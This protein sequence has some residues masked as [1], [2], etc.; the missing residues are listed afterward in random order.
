MSWQNTIQWL[1]DKTVKMDIKDNDEILELLSK[2]LN[3]QGQ[4]QNI[5]VPVLTQK[6]GI[7]AYRFEEIKTNDDYI[8]YTDEDLNSL[9]LDEN[10]LL[11]SLNNTKL[12]WAG[13]DNQSNKKD[14][15]SKNW[16]SLLD[17]Q[18]DI[19]SLV[20]PSKN[21][22][23]SNLPNGVLNNNNIYIYNGRIYLN[24]KGVD[25]PSNKNHIPLNGNKLYKN[26][27]EFNIGNQDIWD[28]I[29]QNLYPDFSPD[30]SSINSSLDA[31][32]VK[33]YMKQKKKDIIIFNGSI[34]IKDNNGKIYTISK[35]EVVFGNA[36]YYKDLL[37]CKTKNNITY[38]DPITF[39]IQNNIFTPNVIIQGF[40][41]NNAS[42]FLQQL[43]KH[44]VEVLK[45]IEG[46][47]ENLSH[48]KLSI[49]LTVEW[50]FW[51]TIW[52]YLETYITPRKLKITSNYIYYENQNKIV[53]PMDYK[54]GIEEI[55]IKY[56][57]LY[58]LGN[59]KLY[60]ANQ[61]IDNLGWNNDGLALQIQPNWTGGDIPDK[62][63]CGGASYDLAINNKG[64]IVVKNNP[65]LSG[66]GTINGVQVKV[67][68]GKVEMHN[69]KPIPLKIFAKIEYNASQ[70]FRDIVVNYFSG[71]I[72]T[73]VWQ[74]KISEE[75]AKIINQAPNN[76]NQSNPPFVWG[77]PATGKTTY[78]A[79]R[80][81]DY[82]NNGKKV[83]ALTPT[84]KAADVLIERI[85]SENPS[86]N[87]YRFPNTRSNNPN[88]HQKILR[89]DGSPPSP[90]YAIITTI[91]RFIFDSIQNQKLESLDWDVVII[92]EAS[93]VELP[94]VFYVIHSY[95]N[96]YI[97][98]KVELIIAGD[99]EQLTPVGKTPGE[100]RNIK[101]Y[102]TENIYTVLDLTF[103]NVN[104]NR[105]NARVNVGVKSF[106]VIPYTHKINNQ[107]INVIILTE[108]HRSVQE[109]G[110][111]YS[112]YRYGG[113]LTHTRGSSSGKITIN[114]Y[115][116]QI[117]IS[118]I[119]VIEFDISSSSGIP[120]SP[121]DIGKLEYSSYHLFSAVLAVELAKE[122][123]NQLRDY[124]I[125]IISPYGAQVKIMRQL[126]GPYSLSLTRTTVDTVHGFQGDERDIIILVMNPPSQKPG[127]HSHF[128]NHRIVNVGISRAKD[129]LIILKPA[130]ITNSEIDN[131]LSHARSLPKINS[132]I[133]NQINN[134]IE[135]FSHLEV[136][137]YSQ[138]LLSSMTKNYI[139]FIDW[140]V[141]DIL[142]K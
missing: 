88:V 142:V 118:P 28:Y 128:N 11:Q 37:T 103:N 80:I 141:L 24:I 25:I 105:N 123:E 87:A 57:E 67:N 132:N 95:I 134:K 30:D 66:I 31:E 72:N 68:N 44:K 120:T 50:L 130:S 64:E 46:K 79:N 63:N 81:I 9:G 77:P 124:N 29:G 18:K 119:T 34:K 97:N 102:S 1:K 111:V 15:Q 52:E 59:V 75:I 139:F 133:V 73:S 129:F 90:P 17:N 65:Q 112:R 12:V 126:A 2:C 41:K 78:L 22:L 121:N 96:S 83:I 84:N 138:S 70:I 74:S 115:N 140:D 13:K 131:A 101:G 38:N 16:K 110:E 100:K 10:V 61:G 89:R 32:V 109:I 7:L 85:L 56:L 27:N 69:N 122:L 54:V 136:N 4:N 21:H 39:A 76:G 53:I 47:V 42:A 19:N 58:L 104:I 106:Q 60:S 5:V 93:M 125:G 43:Q 26:D 117:T 51:A 108:Q 71:I 40:N 92:D 135:I 8:F 116:N 45:V 3:S 36:V 62:L 98:K 114:F 33:E 127:P 82:L 6:N 35:D 86:A 99:P 94:F 137:L 91:H 14:N 20:Q 48:N 49:E 113:K 107:N 55:E 23:D